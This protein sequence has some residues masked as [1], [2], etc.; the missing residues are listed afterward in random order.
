MRSPVLPHRHRRALVLG[1]VVVVAL[2]GLVA[3]RNYVPRAGT[4][5]PITVADATQKFEDSL[6]GSSSA[7]TT[8]SGAAVVTLPAPGVYVYATSG[9]DAV[10]A[11]SGDHH[12]YPAITTITVRT[13]ACGV[14]DR[15]DILEERWEQWERC[16]DQAGEVREPARSTF[17][18][19][20]GQAQT[21]VYACDGD[22]R[23]VDAPAGAMWTV[24]CTQSTATDVY[25][26][27]VV[28]TETRD[29]GGTPVETVHV[30]IVVTSA[31]ATDTR[32]IDSWYLAGTDLLVAQRGASATSNASMVGTVHY[33]EIYEIDLTSLL[34]TQ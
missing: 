19:F 5:T 29:V 23:L 24:R 28:G 15:W 9:R 8:T 31:T 25:L 13:S 11:L 2:A 26:G 10:D 32:S 27:T 3:V 21:D 22:A 4:S 12:D 20:F 18:R 6:S 30:H 1:C 33:S 17:D 7:A 16:A 14:T 34:P